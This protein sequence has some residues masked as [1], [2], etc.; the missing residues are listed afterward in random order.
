MFGGK[1]LNPMNLF[2]FSQARI[3]T[4]T[5]RAE[6]ALAYMTRTQRKSALPSLANVDIIR[7]DPEDEAMGTISKNKKS[8]DKHGE[9]FQIMETT[10]K[11]IKKMRE[12]IE[13][14]SEDPIPPV[15]T[16]YSSP[17]KKEHVR[18][19]KKEPEDEQENEKTAEDSTQLKMPKAECV[20]AECLSPGSSN[21]S[22]HG[23]SEQILYPPLPPITLPSLLNME[24]ASYNI[25]QKP[26]VHLALIRNPAGLSVLWKVEEEDP[27]APPMDSYIVYMTTEKVKGSGIFPRWNNLGAVKA[28]PLPMCVMI[29]KYKP[30]HKVCVAVVGKDTFGRYGPYSEVVTAAIPE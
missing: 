18:T 17:Q 10:K 1:M 11:A 25:P 26:E 13:N 14:L 28:I 15:L 19:L 5:K 4:V 12:D 21:S 29:T 6:A 30:G 9:L 16:P 27:A 8:M 24:A 22:K 7:V 23:D 20:K 3:N 2:F